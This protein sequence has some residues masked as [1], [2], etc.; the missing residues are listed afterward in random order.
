VTGDV[1][2]GVALRKARRTV[3]FA[4]LDGWGERAHLDEEVEESYV[5][6]GRSGGVGTL[7]QLAADGSRNGDVLADG[8]AKD[9]TLGKSKAVA[10]RECLSACKKRE[11]KGRKGG[12]HGGVGRED[13]LVHQLEFLP[14]SRVESNLG[15]CKNVHSEDQRLGRVGESRR[16]RQT[17]SAVDG[18]DSE[19]EGESDSSGKSD[20]LVLVEVTKG[21]H[22]G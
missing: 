14:L 2:G 9:G 7:D 18:E 13:D 15:S 17:R 22:A 4:V 12:E 21:G 10:T 20:L 3:S 6:V 19:N 8:E 1:A 5:V 11:K 16:G